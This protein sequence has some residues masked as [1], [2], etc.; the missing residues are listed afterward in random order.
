MP[1]IKVN[2]NQL[3]ETL[4]ES[5]YNYKSNPDA[6]FKSGRSSSFGDMMSQNFPQKK[7]ASHEIRLF[8]PGKQF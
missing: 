3:N 1:K 4:G 5:L 7:G 8:I 2:I 6:K